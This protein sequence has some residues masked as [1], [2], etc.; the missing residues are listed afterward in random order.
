MTTLSTKILSKSVTIYA[1]CEQKIVRIR[2]PKGVKVKGIKLVPMPKL[3]KMQ[4]NAVYFGSASGTATKDSAFVVALAKVGKQTKSDTF[5]V[6]V[7]GGNKFFYC[8][9]KVWGLAQFEIKHPEGLAQGG[10]LAP[11]EVS[12]TDANTGAIVAYYV[13]ESTLQDLVGTMVYVK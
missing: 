3:E 11:T 7:S 2:V 12:V 5:E 9:P 8:R 4:S 1:H 10:F 13:Y 6:S